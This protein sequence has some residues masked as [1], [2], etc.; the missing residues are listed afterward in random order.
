MNPT[1]I[2]ELQSVREYPSVSIL[3]PTYRKAPDELQQNPV[4]VKNLV[5]QTVDRLLTEFSKRDIQPLLEQL[6]SLTDQIDYDHPQDGLAIFANKNIGRLVYLPF[7]LQERVVVDETFA[8]R[9]LVHARNRSKRYRVLT[10][11]QEHARLFE[12]ERDA[13]V[14]V[15]TNGFPMKPEADGV[16]TEWPSDFGVDHGQ[17]NTRQDRQFFQHV[18]HA[19]EKVMGQEALPLVLAGVDRNIGF[20]NEVSK[21][22]EHVIGVINGSHDRTAAR[23]LGELVWPVAREGFL[24]RR[25]QMLEQLDNAIGAKRSAAGINNCWR[26]AREGRG[27]LLLVEEDF[28]YP[29]VQD[30]ASQNFIPAEDDTL[31]NTISDAVDE[32]VEEVLGK[33]GRVVFVESGTLDQHDRIALTLRY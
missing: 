8:T 4:R 1:D 9:N 17:Y 19:L 32:I 23:E 22:K 29:A 21:C 24:Q 15:T 10:L 16:K 14:E 7:Q 5:R 6:D 27:D 26:M 33:G 12:A 2:S 18:E 28:H 3:L 11:S 25:R 30:D 20:F 31:P 13:L